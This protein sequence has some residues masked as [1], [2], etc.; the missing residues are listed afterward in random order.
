MR[1]NIPFDSLASRNTSRDKLRVSI[2]ALV[3]VLLAQDA[4]ANEAA[5]NSF[6]ERSYL[7]GDWGGA[8]SRLADQGV[9]L[10]LEYT[11]IY[12]GLV[13]GD[14]DKEG[15][16]GG[17]ADVFLNL[18]SGKLGLWRGGGLR[19]HV[20]YRHGNDQPFAGGA[21]LPVNT[22]MLTP[23][24][25]D[26]EVEATSLFLTQVFGGGNVLMVGKINALDLLAADPFFGG[27]GTNRMMNIVFV[28][29][30]NGIIPAVMMGAVASFSAQPVSLTVMVFDPNDRST[31][32]LPDDLFS[33]GT[34]ASLTAAYQSTLAGRKTSYAL[35]GSFTTKNGADFTAFPPGTGTT[36]K[37]GSYN[38]EFQFGHN[39]QE[40]SITGDAWG[41]YLKAATADGNPNPIDYAVTVG[42]GG[43]P[44]FFNRPQDNF[45]VGYFYYAF[46]DKLQ[47]ALEPVADFQDEE[48]VEIYY[49]YAV[50]PWLHVTPDLQ[51]IDPASGRNSSAFV[52]ALRARIR[53]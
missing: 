10:E 13:S 53:F 46:S 45:G 22:A 35:T 50:T 31:D 5:D 24:G 42:I 44:L 38:V 9:G 25:A 34:S 21:L 27:W 39:L 20:E 16:Y 29:P 1:N 18:D 7:T 51:Y 48:G 41:I 23:V 52:A 17:R 30:P 33:D 19:A 47:D 2:G 15:E 8:L 28:A 32:Y 4:P 3:L 14:G 12:Q 49:S 6:S 37:D 40:D 43:R 26:E 11:S 36:E